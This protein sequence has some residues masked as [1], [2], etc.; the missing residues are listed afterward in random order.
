MAISE[1]TRRRALRTFDLGSNALLVLL[2]CA[3]VAVLAAPHALGWRYGILRSGSMSPDMPAGAAIVVAPAGA[4]EI[5]VGDAITYRSATNRGLL[6]THRVVEVTEDTNGT[7][8]YRTKGDANEEPDAGFVTP[9]RLLGRVVFSV[10]YVGQV[11]QHLHTRAGFF[12][13][14]VVPTALIIAIE[15]RELGA[16]IAD[17]RKDRKKSK[18]EDGLGSA[19]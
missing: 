19:A 7:L 3:V 4:D 12:L 15:L 1:Q 2:L 10:P 5:R 16:G 18:T 14:M 9:D 6:V 17:F 8:A 11:S 13:L